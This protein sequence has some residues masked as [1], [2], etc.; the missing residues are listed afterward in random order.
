M[1]VKAGAVEHG[2]KKTAADLITV[3]ESDCVPLGNYLER[4][5]PHF[6]GADGRVM[7]TCWGFPKS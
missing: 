4:V 7:G 2:R 3:V 6:Y 1:G 5:V